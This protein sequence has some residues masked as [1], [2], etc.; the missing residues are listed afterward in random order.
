MLQIQT[1]KLK[2]MN[3][4]NNDRPDPKINRFLNNIADKINGK[5]MVD[6]SLLTESEYNERPKTME[7]EIETLKA[8]ISYLTEIV[9][10]MSKKII[11]S[12]ESADTVDIVIGGHHFRGKMSPVRR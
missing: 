5:A 7:S 4:N 8:Q 11:I 3:N 2:Q 6:D 1:K 10:N 9:E 12:E